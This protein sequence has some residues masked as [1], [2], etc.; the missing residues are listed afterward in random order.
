MFLG[1]SYKYNCNLARIA[2]KR[3]VGR[4]LAREE[5]EEEDGKRNVQKKKIMKLI[6][7]DLVM[8]A[9]RHL[10][11]YHSLVRWV[12][13]HPFVAHARARL[14]EE[15]RAESRTLLRLKMERKHS[16]PKENIA[17]KE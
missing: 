6:E 3:G 13:L 12:V 10:L 15:S 1:G 14:H 7:V 9:S 16:V 17:F 5:E 8:N 2:R 11:D 4:S